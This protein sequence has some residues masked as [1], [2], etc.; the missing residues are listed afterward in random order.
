M[1]RYG[2]VMAYPPHSITLDGAVTLN[3]TSDGLTPLNMTARVFGIAGIPVTAGG[4]A[5]PHCCLSCSFALT[6]QPCLWLLVT[7]TRCTSMCLSICMGPLGYDSCYLLLLVA[8]MG[9]TSMQSPT[10]MWS[11][12]CYSWCHAMLTQ[13]VC[14]DVQSFRILIM[15]VTIRIVGC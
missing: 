12:K 13:T 4:L 2:H 9:L 3:Y 1:L 10:C 7:H 11:H 6:P 14:I 5:C 8:D 15:T